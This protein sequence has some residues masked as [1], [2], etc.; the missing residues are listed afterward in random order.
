MPSE[1]INWNLE[2]P[3]WLTDEPRPVGVRRFTT[4]NIKGLTRSFYDDSR[5]RQAD[6]RDSLTAKRQFGIRHDPQ[7]M[8]IG[9]GAVYPQQYAP[10]GQRRVKIESNLRRQ[11]TNPSLVKQGFFGPPS[12]SSKCKTSILGGPLLPEFSFQDGRAQLMEDYNAGFGRFRTGDDKTPFVH[13]IPH[14]QTVWESVSDPARQV[15]LTQNEIRNLY[16][17]VQPPGHAAP[18][19]AYALAD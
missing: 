13:A 9:N 4:S 12:I 11:G 3:A 1:V 18:R 14:V 17:V 10:G 19:S 15:T 5:A 8:D 2:P 16:P 6:R 7:C